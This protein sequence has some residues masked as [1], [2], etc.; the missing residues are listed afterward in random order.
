M[1]ETATTNRWL[2]FLPGVQVVKEYKLTWLPSDLAAGVA[3]GTVM[4]PVGL[5]F[6]QLAGLP[7]AG[8]Y[9][10]IFPLLAYALFGSSRQLIVS[11]D[12]SMAL[13]VAVSVMPLAAG[14]TT[15]FALLAGAL[16]VLIGVICILGAVFRLGFMADFLA[17]QVTA[18]FMHGMATVSY[19]HLTLP[20]TPYV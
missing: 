18:G 3:L 12:A 13:L 9:T 19:T 11:P 7:M 6:G 1:P 10:A 14:N 5:A 4:I 15:R 16:A 8:L 20:T 17:K 2:H